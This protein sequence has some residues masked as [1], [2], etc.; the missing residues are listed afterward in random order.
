MP[1]AN[2]LSKVVMMDE[3]FNLPLQLV[4]VICIMAM[5]LVKVVVLVIITGGGRL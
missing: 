2:I 1:L 5:I 3:I 4:A